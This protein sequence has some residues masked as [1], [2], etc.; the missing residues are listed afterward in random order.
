MK[1]SGGGS[2]KGDSVVSLAT[3]SIVDGWSV[4]AAMVIS[5]GE[6]GEEV[7]SCGLVKA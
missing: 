7:V 1:W 5:I 6:E 4:V 2:L 3:S